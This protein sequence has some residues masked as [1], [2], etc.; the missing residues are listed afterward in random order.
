MKTFLVKLQTYYHEFF[1]SSDFRKGL[2][3]VY[4]GDILSTFIGALTVLLIIRGLAVNEYASYTAFYSIATLMPLLVGSGINF[5]L[6]R[7]SAEHI[8]NAG[9]KPIELYFINF[10]LQFVLYLIIGM[11][12][13][14]CSDGVTNILF[15]HKAFEDALRYGLI[16]GA[17]TLISQA[18]RGV[19]N[20]EERFGSYIKALWFRQLLIFSTVFIL[21]LLKQLSFQRTALVI[22]FAELTIAGIIFYHIFRDVNIYKNIFEL[23]KNSGIIKHFISS[24]GW[25]IAYFF[26]VTASQKFDVFMLSRFS[27]GEEL[28]NYGV[29]FRYYS[30]AMIVLSS[31]NAVMLPMFSKVDM[32]DLGRQRQF[33]FK[34]LKVTVWLV[35]PLLV[36]VVFGR[37]LFLWINGVQYEKAFYIFIILL[38]G[39]WLNMMFSPLVHIV[40][41]RKAHKFLFFLGVAAF[42]LN[43]IGNY[44]FVP[45]WG[46]YGAAFVTIVSY[47]LINITTLFRVIFSTK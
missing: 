8:S 22:I 21:F 17:G 38:F 23:K 46:G 7:F 40:M 45:R 43:L 26:I 41:A 20:A 44:N 35:F 5:A 47:S 10:I 9:G 11:L 28:A 12:M 4:G 42:L 29:A 31:L 34:W 18:G 33:T 2:T 39:F 36:F 3:K 16:A 15:G 37:T 25:L 30:L 19:Y 13:L 27:S 14:I 32:Q 1:R 24:A 6:V